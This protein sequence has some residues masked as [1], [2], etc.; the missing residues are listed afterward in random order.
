LKVT[1]AKRWADPKPRVVLRESSSNLLGRLVFGNL[2]DGNLFL[3][4]L[5]FDVGRNAF[6]GENARNF[7][8]LN[9]AKHA[10]SVELFRIGKDENVLRVFRHVDDG[11][12]PHVILSGKANPGREAVG[13]HKELVGEKDRA[14]LFG[15]RANQHLRFR[16]VVAAQQDNSGTRCIPNEVNDEN[17][18]RYNR[19]VLLRGRKLLGKKGAT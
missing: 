4:K 2:V 9:Q 18:I 19:Y 17:G 1:P 6:V 3:Q 11:L 12:C 15:H 16:L 8:Q 14:A 7:V 10:L 13:A 5:L